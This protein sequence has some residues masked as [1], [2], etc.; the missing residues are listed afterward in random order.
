MQDFFCPGLRLKQST[1]I[2]KVLS[3]NIKRFLSKRLSNIGVQ[4]REARLWAENVQ[5]QIN[6]M[7]AEGAILYLKRVGDCVIHAATGSGT[8][9]VWVK[10]RNKYP[11]IFPGLSEYPLEVILRVAKIARAIK[12]DSPTNRQVRKALSGVEDPFKGTQLAMERAQ[13]LIYHGT[14][15]LRD[16]DW[17]PEDY[18]TVMRQFRKVQ[19]VSGDTALVKEP[20]LMDSLSI[21]KAFPEFQALPGWEGVLYPLSIKTINIGLDRIEAMSRQ[22]GEIHAA[23]ENGGKMRMF[24]SPYTVIQALLSP[25]HNLFDAYRSQLP[26]DCTYDQL[27][28]ARWAQAQMVL[29]KT[30]HS[31]DLSTAT[32]RFPLDLQIY[33]ARQLNLSDEHVNALII[34]SRGTW[35]VGRELR[36]PFNRKTLNWVVG[37]PLGIRPSMS[38]FSLTHNLLLVGICLERSK[39]WKDCFRVL[40]DDVVINDHEVAQSYMEIMDG[41]G[42]PISYDKSHQSQWFGEFAGASITPSVLLRPGRFRQVTY[43]NVLD[44]SVDLGVKLEGEVSL[45]WLNAQKL[46]LFHLG[47]WSPPEQSWS[48]WLRKNSEFIMAQGGPVFLSNAPF[49]YYAI[50]ERVTKQYRKQGWPVPGFYSETPSALRISKVI[51]QG[52]VAHAFLSY[53]FH[54]DHNVPYIV[55]AVLN[56]NLAYLEGCLFE[57]QPVP[58]STVAKWAADIINAANA[59]L[60]QPPKGRSSG[61]SVL[62]DLLKVLDAPMEQPA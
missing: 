31:V 28:G 5:F 58:S 41:L 12:L 16:V 55:N 40:G 53:G 17:D 39:E 8:K 43:S 44:L 15:V 2:V 9:P 49:W 7:G 27:A 36:G 51:P 62:R 48:Y 38:L 23:Q 35:S 6:S 32:C 3:M 56:L 1:L 34:A 30:V 20:P 50:L 59:M 13:H 24:A 10:T 60:Y 11:V 47:I 37:Q 29:G 54:P 25:M 21:L 22:I 52:H 18:P 57:E 26:T 42:V 4:P 61:K 14:L 45:R 46:Y 33:L 19:S